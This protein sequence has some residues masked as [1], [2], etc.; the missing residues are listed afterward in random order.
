MSRQFKGVITPIVTCFDQN[1][2]F[3]ETNYIRYIEF[4]AEH[5]I[6][7]IFTVGS[8][9]SF[10]FLTINERMRV[11]EVAVRTARRLKMKVLVQVGAP[12]RRDALKLAK[13][14]EDLEVDAIACVAPFYY[15]GVGYDESTLLRHYEAIISAVKIPVHYYNNPKTTGYAL[16][17]STFSK[18][19]DIGISGLKHTG[20]VVTLG[21]IINIANRKMPDCDIMPGSGAI[22][23][24]GFI[25]GCEACVVG[26]SNAFPELVVELYQAIQ[27]QNWKNA[28][29]T[30]LK[31]IEARRIQGLFGLRP[32]ACYD[33]LKMRGL[34]VGHGLEPWPRWTEAQIKTAHIELSQSGLI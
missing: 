33:L 23:L 3:D 21:E 29:I 5:G 12:S 2:E 7:A 17:P 26:T 32:A 11:A 19:I 15:S 30:Q 18:L 10:P 6:N 4:L 13:H 28:Q 24:P 22:M 8:Y 31:I 1:G 9:G 34:N 27:K 25:L 14:A 16:T 20:D